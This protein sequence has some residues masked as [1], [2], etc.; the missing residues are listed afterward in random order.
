LDY[1]QSIK[2][3]ANCLFQRDWQEGKQVVGVDTIVA[4]LSVPSVHGGYRKIVSVGAS[5]QLLLF[6]TQ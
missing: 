4:N 6:R 3:L 1:Q 5:H 2:I